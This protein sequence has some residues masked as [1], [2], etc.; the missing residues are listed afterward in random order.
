VIGLAHLE[1]GPL[2]QRYALAPRLATLHGIARREVLLSTDMSIPAESQTRLLDPI[3]GGRPVLLVVAAPTE[4]KAIIRGVTAA[5]QQVP[6]INWQPVQ[7]NDRVQLLVTGVGKANAAGG[8]AFA[9]RTLQPGAV[10]SLGVGGALPRLDSS[11]DPHFTHAIGQAVRCSR[12]V[13]A[14]EGVQTPG[15]WQTMA[16][17]GFGP[18]QDMPESQSMAITADNL[19][20][21]LLEQA[22]PGIGD[23][24]TVSTCSGTDDLALQT[25]SRSGCTIEAMEGAAVGLAVQRIAPQTPFIE[26]RV[27]SNRTGTDQAWDLT[28]ALHKL[29]AVASVL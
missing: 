1:Q 21:H 17:R 25:V 22:L 6:P 12:S 28:L 19:V 5:D 24:A 29:A 3:L 16:D 7:L 13:F 27:I 2:L 10:I 11:S 9:L 20:L 4:A 8:T 18:R 23:C 14:D 15:G 26:L